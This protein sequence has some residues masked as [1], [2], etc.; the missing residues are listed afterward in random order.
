M[1]FVVAGETI[2]RAATAAGTTINNSASATYI[3]PA[4]PGTTLTTTSNVVTIRVAEVAGITV[5]PH[6]IGAVG[7]GVIVPGGQVNFDFTVTNT[8]NNT[9]SFSIPNT[10]IISGTAGST[11]VGTP[12]I[13][14]DNGVT[15]TPLAT[16]AGTFS[17]S[18]STARLQTTPIAPNGT[19]TL[20]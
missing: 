8:G 11:I 20:R 3:D 17:G 6:A 7:G 5:V 9:N 18:G 15:F 19:S 16:A 14:Y 1:L 2:A 12:E 10:A 13:S 4:V